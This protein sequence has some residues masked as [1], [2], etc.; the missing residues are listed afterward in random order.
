LIPLVLLN[1]LD[2]HPLPVYGTGGNSG[3]GCMSRI[4]PAPCT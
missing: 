2:E 3:T 1:A 4:T